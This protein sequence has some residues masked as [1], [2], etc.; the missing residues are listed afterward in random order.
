MALRFLPYLLVVV[1]L[2]VF[3]TGLLI[4]AI[5]VYAVLLVLLAAVLAGLLVL[6]FG[7]V[8][9]TSHLTGISMPQTAFFLFT[10]LI[11]SKKSIHKPNQLCYNNLNSHNIW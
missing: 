1:L 10:F 6:I 3:L 5:A 7:I 9:H 11:F 4:L 8:L 2:L